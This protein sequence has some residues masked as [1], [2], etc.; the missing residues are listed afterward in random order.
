MTVEI[1]YQLIFTIRLPS[2]FELT[3]IENWRRNN[4]TPAIS[5]SLVLF[6]DRIIRCAINI[7]YSKRADILKFSSFVYN[8]RVSF[9]FYADWY[10]IW[11]LWRRLASKSNIAEFRFPVFSYYKN[12]L[13]VARWMLRF[14]FSIQ[15]LSLQLDMNVAITEHVCV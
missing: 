9:K 4:K 2:F 13:S 7:T 5:R 11:T 8:L 6:C 3:F 1:E 10:Q 15:Q 12:R 14:S